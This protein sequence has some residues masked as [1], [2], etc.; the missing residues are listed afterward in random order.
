VNLQ[1]KA[2]QQRRRHPDFFNPN[3]R[4]DYCHFGQIGVDEKFQFR[5]NCDETKNMSAVPS[6]AD[7]GVSNWPPG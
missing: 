1:F 4:L 6:G 3:A 2:R 7:D 5:S